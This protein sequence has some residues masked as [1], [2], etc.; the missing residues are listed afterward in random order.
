MATTC[1]SISQY[2]FGNKTDFRS[3]WRIAIYALS[4]PHISMLGFYYVKP[5]P[6]TMFQVSSYHTIFSHLFKAEINLLRVD[7]IGHFCY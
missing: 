7:Q 6:S 3:T 4:G 2:G 1:Q 5:L